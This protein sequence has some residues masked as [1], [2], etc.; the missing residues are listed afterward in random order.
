VLR[1]NALMVSG[2][3]R[4][5]MSTEN[6]WSDTNCENPNQVPTEQTARVLRFP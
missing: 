1:N 3:I 6:V 5:C 4:V 2:S